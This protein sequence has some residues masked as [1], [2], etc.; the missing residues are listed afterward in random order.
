[1]PLRKNGCLGFEVVRPNI[2]LPATIFPH[3]PVLPTT[4]S[5]Q[6][7]LACTTLPSL[8][9]QVSSCKWKSCALSFRKQQQQQQQQNKLWLW[10]PLVIRSPAAFHNWM[11]HGCSFWLW[12]SGLWS[13]AWDP[14]LIFSGSK[15]TSAAK[16][17]LLT[18]GLPPR[19]AG[20]CPSHNPT[21]P[22]KCFLSFLDI[23]PPQLDLSC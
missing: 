4:A 16:V 6:A 1:M 2:G 3:L 22:T 5:H 19:E 17:S 8:K 7:P 15:I 12:C 18:L 10:S 21:F 9:S 14:A 23:S 11:L 20:A 13:L